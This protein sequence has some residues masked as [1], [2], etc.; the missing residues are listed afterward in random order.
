[1][2]KINT[3]FSLCT[4][5]IFLLTSSCL[6]TCGDCEG[7]LTIGVYAGVMVGSSGH[8][9]LE[10]KETNSNA[11][12]IFDGNSY[13][14]STTE[15]LI[16]EQDILDLTLSDGTNSIVFSAK[17]DGSN[18]MIEFQILDHKIESTVNLV[19]PDSPFAIYE[20]N[21]YSTYD[22]NFTK[23]TYNLM[24]HGGGNI[25]TQF[26]VLTKVTS[27]SFPDQVGQTDRIK[28][29]VKLMEDYLEFSYQIDGAN[30]KL[31]LLR[32]GNKLK[33]NDSGPNNYSFDIELTKS[34][35]N[36]GDI[37]I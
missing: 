33:L 18:A 25:I 4:V 13:N 36:Y 6:K 35:L 23:S 14:L 3:L 21:S 24:I 37:S 22:T 16:K 5:F 27:S 7:N 9:V 26:T 15:K 31:I 29:T 17:A 34:E 11:I 2:L 32:D 19:F 30:E 10:L 1:M 8:Y 12:I 28:G 20:G